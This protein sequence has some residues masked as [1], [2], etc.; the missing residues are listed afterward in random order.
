M[1]FDNECILNIQSLPGEYFCPVCRTLVYPNEA[2]QAAC[3]HL[4]CKPC[5][6]YIVA[7]T[8]ACPYDGYLVSEADAKPLLESGKQTAEAIEKIEV[9]CLYHRSGCQWQGTL[10][11]C[12]THCSSCTFGNSPVVCNRCGAQIVHRQVQEHAQTCPGVQPQA[13]QLDDVQSQSSALQTQSAA[14]SVAP[15]SQQLSSQL[16]ASLAAAVTSGAPST[17]SLASTVSSTTGPPKDSSATSITTA[18]P[19]SQV[20]VQALTQEQWSQQY[21]QYYQQYPG[22]DAYQQQHQQQYGYYQQQAPQQYAQPYVQSHSVQ[23]HQHPQTYVHQHSQ[24]TLQLPQQQSQPQHT[25]VHGQ[26]HPVQGPQQA[27]INVQYHSHLQP[28]PQA[29]VQMQSHCHTASV[30]PPGQPQ[31]QVPG[32]TVRPQTQQHQMAQTMQAQLL[33]QPPGQQHGQVPQPHGFPMPHPQPSQLQNQPWPQ[34]PQ[35]LARHNHPGQPQQQPPHAQYISHPNSNFQIQSQPPGQNLQLP[36]QSQAYPR[37]H[38]TMQP[39]FHTQQQGQLH[40]QPVR[41]SHLISQNLPQPQQQALSQTQ[42]QQLTSP[43][44]AVTGYHSFPQPHLQTQ[45]LGA[46]VHQRGAPIYPQHHGTPQQQTQLQFPSSNHFAVQQPPQTQ[47]RPSLSQYPVHGPQN[48]SAP[49]VQGSHQHSPHGQQFHHSHLPPQ[50]VQN[51]VQHPK[52]DQAPQHP[53]ISVQQPQTSSHHN[54]IK[55]PGFPSTQPSTQARQNLSHDQMS[56]PQVPLPPSQAASQPSVPSAL[57]NHITSQ[58]PAKPLPNGMTAQP[59]N[60]SESEGQDSQFPSSPVCNLN[61]ASGDLNVSNAETNSDEMKGNI[62][63]GKIDSEIAISVGIEKGAGTTP[64]DGVKDSVEGGARVFS[65]ISADEVSCEHNGGGDAVGETVSTSDDVRGLKDSEKVESCDIS[66]RIPSQTVADVVPGQ[67]TAQES[68]STDGRL[69]VQALAE[70]PVVEPSLDQRTPVAPNQVASSGRLGDVLPPTLKQPSSQ[71]VAVPRHL[72]VHNL[73][74]LVERTPGSSHVRNTPSQKPPEADSVLREQVAPMVPNSEGRF[75]TI[76]PLA[77]KS[78]PPEMQMANNLPSGL[79]GPNGSFARG[80]PSL[81]SPIY[82]QLRSHEPIPPSHGVPGIPR[83]THQEHFGISTS[84][85]PT[86]P[87][88]TASSLDG[89]GPVQSLSSNQP[90]PYNSGLPFLPRPM[91]LEVFPPGNMSAGHSEMMTNGFPGRADS[92]VPHTFGAERFTVEDQQKIPPEGSR[93]SAGPHFGPY[94][95]PVRRVIDRKRFEEDLKQFP[96][97]SELDSERP[98]K[99]GN[100]ATSYVNNLDWN[101]YPMG[102]DSASQGMGGFRPDGI[103]GGKGSSPSMPIQMTGTHRPVG[104]DGL[105]LRPIDSINQQ[106]LFDLNDEHLRRK[107]DTVFPEF[108][109]P[110]PEIGSHHV[111][112]KQLSRSPRGEFSGPPTNRFGGVACGFGGPAISEGFSL[113]RSDLLPGHLRRGSGEDMRLGHGIVPG[114]REMD[115]VNRDVMPSYIH[116]GDSFGPGGFRKHPPRVGLPGLENMYSRDFSRMGDPLP[117]D[118][119]NEPRMLDSGSLQSGQDTLN[120]LRKRQEG[121]TGWCLICNVYCETDEGRNFHY[122]TMEHQKRVMEVV[123]TIKQNNVKKRKLSSE[124]R[125]ESKFRKAGL[126]QRP[127]R[128]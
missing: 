60:S 17:A 23:G 68:S 67:L 122:Q 7:T 22:Y 69:T 42:A 56:L 19:Q 57:S 96:R 58:D 16:G 74:R 72:P 25:Q 28:Q 40:S 1:G 125:S 47:M 85:P 44:N 51:H 99:F 18:T 103:P 26:A 27:Q 34:Q 9:H 29:Q 39:P 5:L 32:Q 36:A 102:P 13:Q 88:V 127:F 79:P 81:V 41:P 43:A 104:S 62:S 10:S 53:V 37:P 113:Q 55:Q 101:S 118:F 92:S 117:V 54:Q 94:V 59:H 87:Y 11:E 78:H 31:G 89:R 112:S 97:P 63:D 114:L 84:R 120:N 128:S 93:P 83:S 106:R 8:S 71:F 76:M 90:S 108:R 98:A 121:C 6:A 82:S 109:R 100:Y 12:V 35:H 75:N 107:T 15:A 86:V 38:S 50:Q 95:D 124:E 33:G 14:P 91:A 119:S 20:P 21:Q 116:N 70:E 24:V 4:Y 48:L 2:L 123:T 46:S 77:S 80:P 126:D 45:M 66:G 110:G 65:N 73:E 111:D 115:T 105:S 3:T 64:T 61:V 52:L 30:G 49:L